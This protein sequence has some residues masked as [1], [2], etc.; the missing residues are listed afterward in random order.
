MGK[1]GASNLGWHGSMRTSL[2]KQ[3]LAQQLAGS[4]AV[5]EDRHNFITNGRVCQQHKTARRGVLFKSVG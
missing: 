2:R 3:K 4:D 5:G 1:N